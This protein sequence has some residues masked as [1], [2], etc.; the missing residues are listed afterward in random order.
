M[1]VEQRKDYIGRVQDSLGGPQRH[2]PRNTTV[3][4]L[5]QH[6]GLQILITPGRLIKRLHKLVKYDPKQQEVLEAEVEARSDAQADLHDEGKKGRMED[7]AQAAHAVRLKA[8]QEASEAAFA[9]SEHALQFFEKLCPSKYYGIS[10]PLISYL[11]FPHEGLTYTEPTATELE[12][13]NIPAAFTFVGQF[14]DHDLT[15]NSLNL[16][17]V[18]TNPTAR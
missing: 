12:N 11:T 5:L 3:A 18:Q 7:A 15:F 2:L 9:M 14:V 4:A 1:S 17:D 16:Y 13:P 10:S 8:D 6:G